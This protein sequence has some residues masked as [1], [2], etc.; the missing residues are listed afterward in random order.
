MAVQDSGRATG[1]PCKQCGM[2]C[3]DMHELLEHMDAHLQEE[4]ERKYKCDE[5]GRGYRHAGSLANHKKTHEVGSFQCNI[6]GKENSNALALKSHL[7]SHTSQKKYSCAECGK[8]F[9]LATQLATHEK[10]HMFRREKKQS[11]TKAD[12]EY[13]AQ[14]HELEIENDHLQHLSEQ[15]AN[16]DDSTENS[17]SEDKSEATYDETCDDAESRP[18]RC[19]ICDKSYIHH[20]SLTNHKKTHQVGMFECTVCFKQFNNMATLYSHQRTHKARSGTDLSSPGESYAGTPVDQFSPQSQD[21]PVNFCHLCQVLFPNDDEFEEHIQMH[22]S[23]SLSFGFHDTVSENHNVSYDNSIA[24]PEANF[25]ASPINNI[26]SVSSVDNH[27]R[28]DPPPEKIRSN[29]HVYSECSS[30]PIPPSNSTQG[31]YANTL[32]PTLMPAQNIGSATEA[33]ETSTVDSDER[34]FKCQICGKSYRHSGSLINHKRSHQ[35]GIYQCS[36]CR[37]SY[38][39]LAALKSHLRLHKAQPSSFHLKTEGDWL[40]SEPLTLDNQ[41][42]CFSSQDVNDEG[43]DNDHPVLG[44]D[45]EN[46]VDHSNGELYH[47]Q[48]NQDFS[49]DMTVH[50]PH[51]EHMMQRHMCADCGETFADIAGIKSHSCP[52]L[53]QQHTTCSDYDSS[54]NLQ[55]SNGLGA[56][57][58]PGSDVDFHVVNGNHDQSYYEQ[59]F[60][61]NPSSDQ[62]N[63][64]RDDDDTD[65]EDDDGDLYQCSICGNSY[66]S[67]RALRSHLR[68][69]TQSNGT[70]ASSGPSSMS[71]HEEVKDEDQGEMMICST[72]GESFA[73]RQDLVSH[74]LLH[75]KDQVDNVSHL[76]MNSDV[77]ESKE[78]TENIICG[79]CGIFCT[80]YHHLT[81]HDCSAAE[82]KDDL[83]HTKEE[84][85]VNDI[86]QHEDASLIKETVD[87]GGRQY[88]CDQC[89]RSYRHAGSLL[90]HKK[91]HKTGVFRCLVCQ[92]RFYNLLALKNHQRSHFDIKR[93]TC[94]ECGKAFKIQK[95]LLNHL[96]RHKEN[97]AK[98]QELN[99]QI[100]ALMQ[101]NGTRSAEGMQ[102]LTSNVNQAFT[103]T[104]R[105]KQLAEEKAI[106]TNLETS[107]K[108]EDTDEQRPFACDQCG[109][110]YRHAGSLVNHRNSH[111]T[112]EYY[113]SVCN[114]TYSNQLAMKNHMR[115]HFAL[116]KHSCQKC[117]KGFRG[118]KQLLAHVCA[119]L[120]KDGSRGRRGLKSRA[121]KCK[122]CKQTFP[123]V[124]QLA[125]HTCDGPSGSR[126]ARSNASPNKEERPFTCNICNRSYRHA[127][128]LLN[129]K[130]THKTGHF[131]CNF[132]SKPF[133]NPMAL[134]NHTR[135]HTQKKKYVC[136]TCGK[137]FRLASI[138]HNHQR[139]HNRVVSHFSCPVC[140]KSFQGRSGLKRHRC[141][142][143]QENATRSGVQQSERG[144]KCFTC[145]LCG[146]SYRHAGSL[147]NHKKTHSDNLHH[148][149]LCL[150]TF[151]DPLT[152]QIHSQMRRHCC[153]ECGK[154]FCLVT[155]LQS[156]ME[157]HSKERTAV[158]CSICQQS[159]PN[160]ASYQEHHDM[161]HAAQ[162]PYQQS[163]PVHSNL[164]WDSGIDQP[165]G[166]GGMHDQVPPPLSHIPESIPNS[167][168]SRDVFV[169]EEK[170]H[171]CEHCGRTY[172]HA[173]S[174]LNHKNSHK[175]GSFF[176]SVCQKEF[177][178]LMA[179][180]NHRR[181][182]TEPKRYQCLEC[183][184]AFRVSTQLICHR[185]IHTKEKPF[186]CVLCDKSFS[187]KSNLRH[188][189]KMHQSNQ[190]YDSSFSMDANAFM[191]LDMGS[192][193]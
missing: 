62:L 85:K 82:R 124:D 18:Y 105:C 163:E 69:H 126:D 185:R 183:G 174:L 122:E 106:Q 96:R 70:P 175:T 84:V 71:S 116:K 110:T 155:H 7:R 25:Y 100:Q 161:H 149:T 158:V 14:E 10:V 141:H 127:G 152:L 83:Q 176:C 77:S 137:A 117:G 90:N 56:I 113:C 8:S 42:G 72:C 97:Q 153:P 28:F 169:G 60:L 120:R 46:G 112:G 125:A 179:L 64:D 136:L 99:N 135:I 93:H 170:S 171:V 4:E 180:K 15:S 87:T 5:C 88:K 54:S 95:Q 98:I 52:L 177:T 104:R 134:R 172:R 146:R 168:K 78:E 188:H 66:T 145:D 21:A 20:R 190:T 159:F 75:N 178:N 37:K 173:G 81:N 49:Q 3:H 31:E 30:N 123:S 57:V 35:V 144:D 142:R 51:N 89:G 187:S 34:P 38:P 150:Q 186:A 138:L 55:A 41:Q 154:T 67:M 22:N 128:S 108:S 94:H 58:N 26:S 132:C 53:Q 115:T 1:F 17:P 111:K 79:R 50:L 80:S 119:D 76:H 121:F 165:M 162:G 143:G 91:S 74:Q 68:G 181:I 24:S 166:M 43:D 140:G 9:R 129:H 156:H 65:E 11:Y 27:G 164:C 13:S 73:N 63:G 12:M 44:M 107:V 86:A 109:R 118:K 33:E 102:S 167:Q 114:N 182:H 191:D 61:E 36:I 189:Q 160:T 147:L 59:N 6:C 193:L 47:E 45:Q 139:V 39:H 48:Y 2:V 133:T 16:V 130:N 32:S 29:G 23:S 101:M 192:F 184:K 103:S 131:S 157:V 151:P 92:K 148:C 19:D 40:S